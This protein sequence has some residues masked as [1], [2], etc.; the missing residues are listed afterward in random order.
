MQWYLGCSTRG[1]VGPPRQ[2]LSRTSVQRRAE[3]RPGMSLPCPPGGWG[4][5]LTGMNAFGE[6]QPLKIEGSVSKVREAVSGSGR[7]FYFRPSK[8]GGMEGQA[9]PS[10]APRVAQRG[11]QGH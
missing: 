3:A 1:T 10:G 5:A 6:G 2:V 9:S 8:G 11:R 7:P 4:A